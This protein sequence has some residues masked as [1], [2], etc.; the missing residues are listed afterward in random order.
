MC[1]LQPLEFYSPKAP[2][3]IFLKTGQYSRCV[4]FPFKNL[5]HCTGE[6]Y[7]EEKGWIGYLCSALKLMS[8]LENGKL[9]LFLF[10]RS[11]VE[12]ICWRIVRNRL[13][14][15]DLYTSVLNP[16]LLESEHLFSK[17]A[18]PET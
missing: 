1:L 15:P 4:L 3:I 16:L 18:T 17:A 7:S 5:I 13:L 9:G 12:A 14:L 6:K 10:Q 8:W 11:S 2:E